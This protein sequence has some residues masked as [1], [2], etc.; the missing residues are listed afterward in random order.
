M[1]SWSEGLNLG[2]FSHDHLHRHP[3]L[4]ARFHVS[5]LLAGKCIQTAEGCPPLAGAHQADEERSL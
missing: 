1:R 4:H 3:V 5:L 2:C